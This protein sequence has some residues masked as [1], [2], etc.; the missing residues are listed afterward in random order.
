LDVTTQ[1]T[2]RMPKMQSV[3]A[4]AEAIAV[5]QSL[6]RRNIQQAASPM[7]KKEAARSGSPA[8]AYPARWAQLLRAARP[9]QA[10]PGVRAS[11]TTHLP[12]LAGVR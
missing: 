5:D 4:C 2:T 10:G 9:R 3:T 6:R 11:G 7:R 1:A 12:Q 8:Q